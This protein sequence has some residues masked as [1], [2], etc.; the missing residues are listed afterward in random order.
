MGVGRL[1]YIT[2]DTVDPEALA[3]FWA[4]LLGVEIAERVDDGGYVLLGPTGEGVPPLAF[5]RVPEPKAG[6]ARV[7]VDVGV[8]DLDEAM[9]AIEALGGAWTEV[10]V[11][12][13]VGDYRWRVMADPEG[14]EFCIASNAP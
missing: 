12:R 6:K 5:Q 10:G 3:P 11:T 1:S 14:N 9:R 7:H 13:N 2:V 4:A 8:D